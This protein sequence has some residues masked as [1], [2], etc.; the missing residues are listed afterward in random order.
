MY[1]VWASDIDGDGEPDYEET[2]YD[3]NY[4]VNG[5]QNG[6][7]N[8]P[9]AYINGQTVMLDTDTFPDKG[10]RGVHRAGAKA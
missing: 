9:D 2:K 10:W 8:V 3:L 6:P 5:G 4:D 7:A 1:A